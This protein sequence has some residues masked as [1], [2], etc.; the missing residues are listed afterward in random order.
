MKIIVT[1]GAGF[2]GSHFV[3]HYLARH[4]EDRVATLDSLTYAGNKANLGE[5]LRSP[6]HRFV[7]GDIRNAG[8]LRKILPGV[9]A[10]VHF[11]A[12]THVDRSLLSADA[13][14]QTNVQGTFTLAAAARASGVKRFV[15][16]STDEVYGSIARGKTPE[17]FS[18]NPSSPSTPPAKPPR[19][20]WPSRFGTPSGTG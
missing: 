7:K 17:G 5:A 9:D 2:I 1:G 4:R 11:A 13:F 12:E 19:T 3:N 10:V 20:T 8:L 14:I 16:V 6:R 18:L 15:H